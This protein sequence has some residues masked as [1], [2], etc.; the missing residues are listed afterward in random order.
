MDKGDIRIAILEDAMGKFGDPNVVVDKAQETVP[1]YLVDQ[2]RHME[3]QIADLT[4]AGSPQ[5]SKERQCT[6]VL[7]GLLSLV[8]HLLTHA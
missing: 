6:A 5:G 2:L 8:A 3:K 4:K 1:K 7:F